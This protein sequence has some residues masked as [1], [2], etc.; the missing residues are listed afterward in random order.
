MIFCSSGGRVK[1]DAFFV[2]DLVS[3]EDGSMAATTDAGA[4]RDGFIRP[5]DDPV[6]G[7]RGCCLELPL[8][9][10]IVLGVLACNLGAAEQ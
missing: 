7:G 10:L 2:G 4:L 6:D 3:R 5:L 1:S 8:R 9:R